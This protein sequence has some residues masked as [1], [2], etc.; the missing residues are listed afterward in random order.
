MQTLLIVPY[1]FIIRTLLRF[2][3]THPKGTDSAVV[4]TRSC[5][6]QG[7]G[8]MDLTL[9]WFAAV[10]YTSLVCMFLKLVAR[11]APSPNTPHTEPY[12]TFVL[13]SYFLISF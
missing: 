10:L 5:V 8:E 13:L 4:T 1:E 9:A 12:L 3:A 2:G 11:D 7:V 6:E